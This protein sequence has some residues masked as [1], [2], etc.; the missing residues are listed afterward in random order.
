[1]RATDA[2]GNTGAPARH[3]WTVAPPQPDLV[4]SV[5][6][7]TSFTVTNVGSAPAGAFAVSVTHVGTYTFA[8]LPAGQS[9]TRSWSPCRS[10]TITAIADRGGMVEESDER[11]N[12]RSLVPRC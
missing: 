8:G 12:A 11:N 9:V 1:M 10:G 6:T 4:V 5:L 2:A 7:P 3:T